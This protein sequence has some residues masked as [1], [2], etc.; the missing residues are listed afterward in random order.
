MTEIKIRR[1]NEPVFSKNDLIAFA[2]YLGN[3]QITEE[4]LRHRLK[5]WINGPENEKRYH[6]IREESCPK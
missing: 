4:G 3:G 6:W 2:R 1:E 5:C